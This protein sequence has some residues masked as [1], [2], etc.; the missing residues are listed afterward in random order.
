[1]PASGPE[2]GAVVPERTVQTHVL[3]SDMRELP[4]NAGVIGCGDV[5]VTRYLPYLAHQSPMISIAA[6]ADLDPNRAASVARQ[7]GLSARTVDEILG[8]PDV[9]L[10]LNLTPPAAHVELNS[11]ALKQGKHVYSEKPFATCFADGQQLIRLAAASNRRLASAPDTILG[12]NVQ[13]AQRLIQEGKIGRPLMASMSFVT[14]DRSWHPNPEFFYQ[15]GGGPIFDEAPYFLAA[16]VAVLG[17]VKEVAAQAATFRQEIRIS[18]GPSQGQIYRPTVPTSYVA[19]LLLQSGVLVTMLMSFDVRGTT[20]PPLELYGEDGTLR[21]GFPGYYN[22]PVIFGTEHDHIAERIFPT[23]STAREEARGIGV[24]EFARA[25]VTGTPSR[26]EGD[27]P[28]HLLEVMQAIVTAGR[29]GTRQTLTHPDRS[30]R[31]L[32]P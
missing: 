24:E 16:L 5:A 20:M 18:S 2:I 28:L 30:A 25:I 4:L 15:E 3:A 9:D 21:L 8:D 29:T 23:W 26:L 14:A 7:F 6:C 31:S 12:P 11:R 10:V 1:M 19:T 32:R 13:L 17:P 27:F 22:G